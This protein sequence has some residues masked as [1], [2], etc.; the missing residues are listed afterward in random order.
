[1][2]HQIY[3]RFYTKKG[4]DIHISYRDII[5]YFPATRFIFAVLSLSNKTE[6][7]AGLPGNA[8]Q[9]MYSEMS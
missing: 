2:G 5:P 9:D 8:S 1:M 7:S 4:I 6:S 3:W